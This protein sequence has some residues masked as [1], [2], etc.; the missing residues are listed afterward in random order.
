[1]QVLIFLC[2]DF[3]DGRVW[4]PRSKFA[5]SSPILIV[6]LFFVQQIISSGHIDTEQ[7]AMD[8]HPHIVVV[9]ITM[10]DTRLAV[11]SVEDHVHTI[12]IAPNF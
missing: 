5:S 8:A 3:N 1:M 10:L 11:H 6:D 9:Y 2:I 12:Y 4:R 7:H